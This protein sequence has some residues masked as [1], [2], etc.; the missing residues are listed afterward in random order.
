MSDIYERETYTTENAEITADCSALQL[1]SKQD[2][3]RYGKYENEKGKLVS[4]M[5]LC[6][7]HGNNS[8]INTIRKMDLETAMM[9]NDP[10]KKIN[11]TVRENT[12]YCTEEK[13]TS[14]STGVYAKMYMDTEKKYLSVEIGWAGDSVAQ[15]YKSGVLVYETKPHNATHVRQMMRL[16]HRGVIDTEEP[17]KERNFCCKMMTE[18]TMIYTPGT[19]VKY[20]TRHTSM[21]IYYLTP[22]SFIGHDDLMGGE[23]DVETVELMFNE[24][25]DIKIVL[26][27]DGITD[28]IQNTHSVLQN[29]TTSKEIITYAEKKWGDNWKCYSGNRFR[30]DFQKAKTTYFPKDQRDDCSVGFLQRRP[31]PETPCETVFQQR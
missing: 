20:H 21:N 31:L 19:Y 17:I 7:G 8:C 9:E 25:D 29:A 12:L 1:G 26:M 22:S 30:V 13:F 10:I 24:N 3:V 18:D 2:F 27:S 15:V 14:G 28:V 4:W 5:L 23:P 16:A 6:D 11:E